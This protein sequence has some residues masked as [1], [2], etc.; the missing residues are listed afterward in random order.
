MSNNKKTWSDYYAHQVFSLSNIILHYPYLLRILLFKPSNILEIGCG[1]AQHSLFIKS[2]SKKIKLSVLDLDRELLKK[3]KARA[4]DNIEEFYNIDILNTEKV[5]KLPKFELVIS[6]GLLEHFNDQD[7]LKIIDNF[8]IIT[9]RMIFSIP[10]NHYHNQDFGNEILRSK[11]S[12]QR[13]L[14]KTKYR[15]KV[16][17][18]PLD[19]GLRTKINLL[20][21]NN[22]GLLESLRLLFFTSCHLL[23]EITY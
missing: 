20:K 22:L 11:A 18:Y 4:L 1:P 19:I 21:Q 15:F 14:T 2:I 12:V 16:R 5:S 10:S 8:S 3:V 7:F 9:N 13:L 17:N 23:V 6:Q